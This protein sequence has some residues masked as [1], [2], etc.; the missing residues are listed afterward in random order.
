MSHLSKPILGTQLNWAH[1]L[2]KGLAGF[3]LMNE[4]HG[5][6]I[7]DLS[8]NGNVGTLTNMAFPPTAASGWN[9]GRKGIGLKFDG[10][11]DSVNCGN[12]LTLNLSQDF[13][14]AFWALNPSALLGMIISKTDVVIGSNGGIQLFFRA[15]NPYFRI[16]ISDGSAA[17]ALAST[18]YAPD[19]NFHFFVITRNNLVANMYIDGIFI[20]KLNTPQKVKTVSQSFTIGANSFDG[21]TLF[22]GKVD[23]VCVWKRDLSAQEVLQLYT[24]PYCM[25]K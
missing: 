9:P 6:K 20:S 4:G 17:G 25:F 8:M 2:N 18:T 10:V 14:I 11:N 22:S 19:N 23:Q 7:Q 16:L 1:P 3:W 24:D 15:S 13:T 21:L 5:N 12:G